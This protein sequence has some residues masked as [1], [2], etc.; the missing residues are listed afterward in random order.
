VGADGARSTVREKLGIRM[1][2]RSPLSQHHNIV[3]RSPGLARRHALGPAVMYWLVNADVPAVVAPL[4]V[5]D[6]WTFGCPKLTIADAKPEAM[7]RAALALDAD[8]EILSRDDWTAHQLVAERYRAGRAFLAG[9]ACHLHPPFGGYGMNMGIGDAVDLGWKLA[10]TLAGWGGPALLDSYEIER[11]PI[12]RRVVDES[13]INLG[14]TSHKLVLGGIEDATPAGD[15][16]RAA[17]AA[18]ILGTKRR[19]F[20]SLGVVL[21]AAYGASPVLGD[22]AVAPA[23]Q[24]ATAYTPSARAGARAPHAW[25]ADGTARGASLFR[26]FRAGRDDADGDARHAVRLHRDGGGGRRD[27][28][29]TADQ[30]RAARCPRGATLRS[31]AR[32]RSPRPARRVARRRSCRGLRDAAA[33][34]GTQRG[35]PAHPNPPAA[36]RRSESQGG[37]RMT[38]HFCRIPLALLLMLGA[39]AAPGQTAAPWPTK[40]V[41]L[42]VPGAAGVAPDI[43][44]RLLG[45]KLSKMWN[46]PVIVENRPGAGGLIGF[47]AAKTLGKDDHTFIFAPASAYVL[48]PYMF[49]S[50]S[51]DIVQDF[52]P[53]AMVGISPMMAAVAADSPANTL[54][55]ALAL[56]RKDPDKFVVS[57]TAQFTVPNLAVD[58]ITKASGV[59][60][61]AIPYT[62]S[63]QSISSVLGG[64]AP[65]LIDG[66]PP[67]DPMI[68]GKKLK[69]VAIFP[70]RGCPTAPTCRRRRR[71]TRRW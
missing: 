37:N 2:G 58:M 10:A 41:Q 15:A 27:R 69:A 20:D 36:I 50:Q 63:G 44:A 64:D 68:K 66:V 65:M 45:E 8:V 19:E 55:E 21:G 24:D 49:K 39:T 17:A 34:R 60:L 30:H 18:Q 42:I 4:D 70:R 48:T 5:G 9:D 56:A 7:I 53:V 13:V 46:Q 59:P 61:R 31:T 3:F 47:Q 23:I 54:A 1:E 14:F 52:V 35:Q 67:I 71:P 6:L 38:R 57:T 33:R 32:P 11:R 51:V 22:E 12:H 62:S 28:R 25:L 40:P 26:P 29:H 43:M 16:A